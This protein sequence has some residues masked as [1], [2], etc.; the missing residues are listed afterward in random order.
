[1]AVLKASR[2]AQNVMEAEFSFN[3]E[4][5]M[6]NVSGVSQDF[7]TV[8]LT[9]AFDII[10][11]PTNA[12]VLSG[13]V[14]TEEVCDTASFAVTIGD[15]SSANRYLASTDVK[16]AGLVALT[17]TGYVNTGGLNLRLTYTTADVCTTGRITVRIEYIVVGRANEAVTH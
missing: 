11:L 16:A 10:N 8:T 3:V 7:G 4:D 1:M 9:G 17:P 5:T 6:V 13:S 14:V 12:V 2:T 15:S